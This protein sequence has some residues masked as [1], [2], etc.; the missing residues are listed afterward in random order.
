MPAKIIILDGA[1]GS[2]KTTLAKAMQEAMLPAVW[3]SFS[4]DTVL[5]S[6]PPSV[7]DRCN[8]E[9]DWEGVDYMSIYSGAFSCVDALVE[10]GNDVILDVVIA[11]KKSADLL[12]KALQGHS[13]FVVG[14]HCAWE[15]LQRRTLSRGDRTL[16]EARSSFDNALQHLKYDFTIDTTDLDPEQAAAQCVEHFTSINHGD[17]GCGNISAA[18]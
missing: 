15:E 1:S 11:K 16:E 14:L 3:L 4:I 12:L 10:A 17:K 18:E 9:N 7:L 13:I 6:L 5:Y 8:K 2:G